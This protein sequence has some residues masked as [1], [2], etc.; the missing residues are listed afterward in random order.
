M[1]P[2]ATVL[3]VDDHPAS[4]L[5][6]RQL[7]EQ[8]GFS[9]VDQ[10]G[11]GEDAIRKYIDLQPSV[12]VMDL[13]MDGIGGREAIQ[14]IHAYDNNARIV[15]FTMHDDP[16]IAA[17]ALRS[18]ATGYVTK[19]SALENLGEAVRSAAKGKRYL[20]RDVAQDLA[21]HR[22]TERDNPIESLSARE[23]EIFRL[24]AEGKTG[25]QISETLSLSQKTVSNYLSRI[26]QKLDA[27]SE[28]ELVHLAISYGII[29]RNVIDDQGS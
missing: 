11:N 13:S 15:V 25:V 1:K 23:F 5:G 12:V 2:K 20:S 4:M 17:R 29:K 24:K 7:I 6:C 26:R 9:I 21:L 14:R 28:A 19:S 10:A 3:I 16:L 8:A 22:L 18:G 27:N